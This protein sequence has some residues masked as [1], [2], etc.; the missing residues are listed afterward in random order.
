[1]ENEIFNKTVNLKYGK[2]RYDK[3]QRVLAYIF[4]DNTNINLKIVENGLA[5]IYFPSG[6]DQHYQEFQNA[7]EDCIDNQVNLCEPSQHVCAQCISIN[8]NNIINN[9]NFQ[10]N[11]TNWRIKGEGRENIIFSEVLE[12]QEE[13]SF[14]LELTET[15]DTL[16]LRDDIG[17][18]VVWEDY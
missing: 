14:E 7:W 6:K 4:L 1:M 5:N 3:Y 8:K 2:E 12:S 9:C 16:F 15:G 10:C 18:L 13:T 17:K 11:I